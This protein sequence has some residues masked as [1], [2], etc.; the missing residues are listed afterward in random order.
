MNDGSSVLLIED[1]DTQ[2]LLF[3][4]L[5]QGAGLSVA[6]TATAEDGLEHLRSRR[7]DLVVVDYH[8]PKLQGDEF[9]RLIRANNATS[10]IP[11][12]ILTE[13]SASEAERHGL[14]CGADDYV[15]KSSDPDVLLARIELMMRRQRERCAQGELEQAFFTAQR[16]LVTDDSPTYLMFLEDELGSEGYGVETATGGEAALQAITGATFDCVL[17]DLMM[18]GM[19]GLELCRRLCT[20]RAERHRSFP[21]LMVTSHGTK[22][23]MMEALDAGADDFVDKASEPAVLKA[24]IRALLRRKLL[25]DERQ[26][27]HE[28]LRQKEL[29]I[30][31]ERAEK[32][33]ALD[34]ARLVAQLE[35]A[36]KELE[37]FAYAVS[38]DLRAP[39]RSMDGFSQILLEDHADRLDEEGK[40]LLARVRNAAHRMGQLIDDLLKLSRVT[41][42]PLQPAEVDLSEMA[43]EIVQA[44]AEA[45]PARMVD[46]R[47]EPGVVACCDRQLM[48]I[49]LVNLLENAWKYTRKKPAPRIA[50]GRGDGGRAFFVSDNGDGF[51]MAHADKLFQPFKRL[52]SE[53][54]FP[55][56][57]IGL[58]TVARVVNRHG[59]SIE[60]NSR[61]GEG[62][63]FTI[64]L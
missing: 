34:R 58:A 35:A 5:L 54:D 26:R 46:V 6:R 7:P 56:T 20:L 47:V 39:L 33:A 11:L 23:K 61:K 15:A 10:D 55:G 25:Q 60:A 14:N 40:A 18:P 36:N 16:I 28:E 3:T 30:V 1:S 41:T 22:E 43:G 27:I 62:A 37:A 21:I 64:I 38:H 32:E 9:C 57:G 52:H 8:L 51:D 2:A 53:A 49:A 12:M 48:R 59:G 29:E 50:F 45:E 31:R 24:R 19:D 4:E 17:I 63:V 13:V 42:M 44:L